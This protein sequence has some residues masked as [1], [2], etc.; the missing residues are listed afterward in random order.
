MKKTETTCDRCG[1][2]VTE[3]LTGRHTENLLVGGGDISL[4]VRVVATHMPKYD[5]SSELRN[6]RTL[7]LPSPEADLCPACVLQVLN[8]HWGRL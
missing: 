8:S 1:K 6:S 4:S 5:F 2:V 7:T 3:Q